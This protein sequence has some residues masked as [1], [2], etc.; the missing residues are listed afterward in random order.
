MPAPAPGRSKWLAS[1]SRKRRSKSL[2]SIARTKA[3]TASRAAG[4]RDCPTVPWRTARAGPA[5]LFALFYQ[6]EIRHRQLRRDRRRLARRNHPAGKRRG[7][8][9]HRRC[10]VVGLQ[11]TGFVPWE[12]RTSP[13]GRGRAAGRVRG[14]AAMPSDRRPRPTRRPCGSRSRPRPR[15]VP[16]RRS[17]SCCPPPERVARPAL[18]E[19]PPAHPPR[20]FWCKPLGHRHFLTPTGG[21]IP[22]PIGV[23][24]CNANDASC[25]FYY[26]NRLMR[27]ALGRARPGFRSPLGQAKRPPNSTSAPEP[28]RSQVI[29]LSQAD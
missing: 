20:R 3:S 24:K 29:V 11:P 19:R 9:L 4:R 7:N 17:W 10:D 16:W 8:R 28:L 23:G 12:R 18:F 25:Q 22:Q 1:T 14:R 27:G 26:R 21:P 15:A 6:V 5:P 2:V 13:C